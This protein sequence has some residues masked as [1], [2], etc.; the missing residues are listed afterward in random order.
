[1]NLRA[2]IFDVYGTLLEIAAPPSDADARWDLLWRE[3]LGGS[4]RVTLQG[5]ARRCDTIIAREHAVSRSKGVTHP[6]VRWPAVATEAVPELKRLSPEA[7][8]EFLFRQAQLWHS[9]SLMPGAADALRELK[10]REI[11]LGLVSNAQPYTLREL[12]EALASE[13]L[14]RAMF[15]RAVSFFSFEHGFGKPDPQVFRWLASRLRA[16]GPVPAESLVVGDRMDNDIAPARLE[17]FQTWHL[18]PFAADGISAGTWEQLRGKLG[19][20]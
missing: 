9:V 18:T 15:T 8:D 19:R 1:M 14:T 4:A 3:M 13:G 6:E 16:L 7:I 17:G 12:D 11:I 5:F 20:R 2:V 10:Q